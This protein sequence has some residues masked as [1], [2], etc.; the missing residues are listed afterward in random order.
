MF[1]SSKKN[2]LTRAIPIRFSTNII[3]DVNVQLR[4]HARKKDPSILE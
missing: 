2:N 3:Y 1:D 4:Y